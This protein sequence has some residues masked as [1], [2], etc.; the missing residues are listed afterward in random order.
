MSDTLQE[1]QEPIEESEGFQTP[2]LQEFTF[3]AEEISD[4]PVESS[5]SEQPA[6][7]EIQLLELSDS[8]GSL[9]FYPRREGSE[10][11]VNLEVGDVLFLRKRQIFRRICACGSRTRNANHF[12][13]K[14]ISQR[15]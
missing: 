9:L 6:L 2:D 7:S 15:G 3:E 14:G 13:Q 10:L 5:L 1:A 4:E 8:E 12:R 11:G